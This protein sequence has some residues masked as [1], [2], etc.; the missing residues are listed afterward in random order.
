VAQSKAHRPVP[1]RAHNRDKM[2]GRRSDAVDA[3]WRV[4]V[5]DLVVR[6]VALGMAV[7]AEPAWLAGQWI[8][9][10]GSIAMMFIAS[11]STPAAVART[12]RGLVR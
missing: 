12:V 11:G 3:E 5:S 8:A 7:A 9:L 6:C 1:P 4:I 10:I 2:S